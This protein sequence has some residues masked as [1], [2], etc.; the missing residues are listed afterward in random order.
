MPYPFLSLPVFLRKHYAHLIPFSVV[1][2]DPKPSCR[3]CNWTPAKHGD[4]VEQRMW[5]VKGTP[6]CAGPFYPVFAIT[7][8][9]NA[10]QRRQ[11]RRQF[12]REVN[13]A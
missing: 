7:L 13:R 2:D 5:V 9:G 6:Q 11:Q 8:N 10:K 3:Y 4:C 12:L 1:I